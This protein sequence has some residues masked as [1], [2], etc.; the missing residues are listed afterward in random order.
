MNL[1]RVLSG[2]V[3]KILA[4]IK[5][6]YYKY[7]G[8]KKNVYICLMVSNALHNSIDLVERG[9][10]PNPDWNRNF[11]EDQDK[12]TRVINEILN[13]VLGH[14]IENDNTM[15]SEVYFTK[16]WGV[17]NYCFVYKMRAEYNQTEVLIQSILESTDE[18][19]RWYDLTTVVNF[20]IF[21][22]TPH[23]T[24][25]KTYLDLLYEYVTMSQ[26]RRWSD[27]RVVIETHPR[28]QK[29]R[30]WVCRY[31]EYDRVTEKSSLAVDPYSYMD[32]GREQREFLQI[33]YDGN[34]LKSEPKNQYIGGGQQMSY[35]IEQR[36][37]ERPK[38]D[39]EWVSKLNK[40]LNKLK[41]KL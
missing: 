13:M 23:R 29:M 40:L 8:F 14:H 15:L 3:L 30:E 24:I 41:L 39:K 18:V 11:R 9:Y 37:I 36:V 16:Y 10:R 32:R 7:D 6:F 28:I 2:I 1:N 27:V 20:N 21:I 33:R 34:P 31:R 17:G 19:L 5:V 26:S 12:V 4:L 38:V 22:I 35:S 25:M